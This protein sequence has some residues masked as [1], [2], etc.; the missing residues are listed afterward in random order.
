[1]MISAFTTLNAS[2]LCNISEQVDNKTLQTPLAVLYSII[3]ILGLTGNLVAL[4]VFFFVHS[5]KNSLWI[6]LMNLALADLL[7]VVCLP[8]RIQYHLHENEWVLGDT[9]CKLVGYLFYMNMYVSITLLGLISVD[10]YMKIYGS[11]R[12]RRKLSSPKWSIAACAIIWVVALTLMIPFLR[13]SNDKCPNTKRCFHYRTI[14]Q[15]DLWKAHINIFVLVVFWLVFISLVLSYGKIALKLLRRS[16]RRPDLPTAPH[17]NRVARK[18]FFVLF[19]FVF[20]FVP[21]HAFRIFYIKT[22][23]SKETS[24]TRD[25]ADKFNEISLVFSALNSCLDPVM[26]FMLSSSVRKEVR[27]FMSSVFCTRE[28]SGTI[29]TIDANSSTEL[30]SRTDK[31]E[32]NTFSNVDEKKDVLSSAS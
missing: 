10:R 12:T 4:W 9:M 25:L 20:C 29:G 28:T 21:Y 15:E 17:Y 32:S 22:Q 3:F 19:L 7:L 14:P 11:A 5:K 24:G 13:K 31:R 23:I 26:F 27:R 2:N 30:D 6:F 16:Q 8:F 18:S 1:M